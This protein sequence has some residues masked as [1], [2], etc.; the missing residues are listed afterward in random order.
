MAAFAGAATATI[1]AALGIGVA[2]YRWIA[3]YAWIDAVLSASMILTGMGPVGELHG[4]AAKLFASAYALFSGV[5]FVTATGILFAP[6]VHR[7]L[8]RYHAE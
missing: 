3:G 7:L 6:I 8:H 2:G 5:V 1:L 4:D